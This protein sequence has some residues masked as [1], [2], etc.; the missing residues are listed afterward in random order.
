MTT[1]GL[2]AAKPISKTITWG[3]FPI[4]KQ[5]GLYLNLLS[6]KH[7]KRL[8]N[9]ILEGHGLISSY[10]HLGNDTP[11]WILM[12]VFS[13]V[14]SLESYNI[15][16]SGLAMHNLW[17]RRSAIKLQVCW[18]QI[19]SR[20]TKDITDVLRVFWVLCLCKQHYLIFC[21]SFLSFY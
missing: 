12:S 21:P 7:L 8:C 1:I 10:S 13:Y 19:Y 18:I 17:N 4:A 11:S 3:M 16:N 20:S 9:E 14:Y 15:F 2:C 5:L 6:I